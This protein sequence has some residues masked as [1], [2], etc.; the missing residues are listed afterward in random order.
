MR[1]QRSFQAAHIDRDELVRNGVHEATN[2]AREAACEI[3]GAQPIS[4]LTYAFSIGSNRVFETMISSLEFITP[5]ADSRA[6][7][8]ADRHPIAH[9]IGLLGNTPRPLSMLNSRQTNLGNQ[10]GLPCRPRRTESQ[11]DMPNIANVLKSEISRIARKEVRGETQRL[12]KAAATHRSDIAA[13]KRLTQEL[14]AQVRKL[15]KG[16]AANPTPRASAEAQRGGTKFSAKALAAQRKRLALS[17]HELGL[18][19][20][21]SSQ[22]IYNWEDGTATPRAQFL[23]AVAALKTLTKRQAAELV[24]T[25]KNAAR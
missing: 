9:A 11:I 4:A 6:T 20:G 3:G 7:W 22:S 10:V 18:L 8:D 15:S 24:G 5:K 23:P 14:Q 19:I 25:R 21:V 16:N 1:Y 12:K 13:L 17:A 2:E